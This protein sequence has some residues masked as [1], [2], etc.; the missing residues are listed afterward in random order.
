MISY[1]TGDLLKSGAEALVNTVNCEGYMGKGIAYQFKLA[2]PENNDDY[3]R[4]CKN[5]TLHIGT[6]HHYLEKGKI[7][8][9]F[10]TKDKWRAKS[11]MEYIDIGLDQLI[12]LIDELEIKSIAI[13]PLGSGNGGL[14]WA[15]VK[16]LIESKLGPIAQN[17]KL[18]VFIYEPS[19]NYV[20]RP[21]VEPKLSLSSLVLMQIKLHLTKFNKLRLQKTAYFMD[22][23]GDQ[24]YFRFVKHKYGPYDHDIDV[25]SQRIK[26]FQQYHNTSSTAEAYEIAYKKLTS[27]SVDS[28]L[29]C[30][31]PL[32]DKAANYVN[33]IETDSLLECVSTALFLLE[34]NGPS[35]EEEIIEGFLAWSEDKAKRF[36]EESIRNGIRYLYDTGVIEKTLSGYNIV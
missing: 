26:E 19:K 36:P 21:T 6:L 29:K 9:N 25:V 34:T 7:I 32:I 1:T 13:P 11:K 5:G 28:R 2:F 10:P 17:G 24:H 20:A 22:L 14:V 27:D 8:V 18:D 15:D 31:M 16:A 4:A 33:G 23:F 35:T 30:F 12:L 3:I